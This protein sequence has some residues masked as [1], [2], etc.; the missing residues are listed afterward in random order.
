MHASPIADEL[1]IEIHEPLGRGESPAGPV[2]GPIA[3]I[4]VRSAIIPVII[5]IDSTVQDSW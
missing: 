4:A 3:H 1:R 2:M 5:C